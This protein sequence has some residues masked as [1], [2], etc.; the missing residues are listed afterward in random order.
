MNQLAGSNSQ[1][2]TQSKALKLNLDP[3]IYGTFAEIGAGQEIA[4]W[5]FRVGG[6]SGTVAKS[7][8]AYDMK[9]SDD[10][11]GKTT[12]YV[13]EE[14]LKSMLEYE[15]KLLNDRLGESEGTQRTFF[16]LANTIS[17]RNYA[18][19]N[20]CHGWM[21]IRFQTESLREPNDILLHVNLLDPDNLLQ[22]KAIGTLGVNLIY[23]A[24]HNNN[25]I[26]DFL[27]SLMDGLT[28]E[29]IEIDV[30]RFLGKKFSDRDDHLSGAMLV[31]SGL[32]K[33]VIFSPDGKLIQPS[34]L[35]RKK[36]A[37]IERGAFR[38][39]NELKAETLERAKKVFSEDS[40]EN[41][42]NFI[43]EF[44]M[45]SINQ[46]KK[47]TPSE[48]IQVINSLTGRNSYIM[49]SSFSWFY[50]LSHYMRRYTNEPLSF[51]MGISTAI[52]LL[53]ESSYDEESGELLE[54]IGK[55]LSIGVK[56]LSY[57][58]DLDAV[59]NYL[60]I[61][62]LS[63][64]NWTY[65]ENNSSSKSISLKSIIPNSNKA[66]LYNYLISSGYLKEV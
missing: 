6:A 44:S 8:S 42:F 19:T 66:H 17:A 49:I 23:S 18:G 40:H 47:T 22:Q 43:T 1:L 65:L 36:A 26:E 7:M 25:S 63:E 3:R 21:G 37:L 11:Y 31:H 55:L 50:S 16:A 29:R 30:V 52:R 34:S 28:S 10:I 15:Y 35:I 33:A 60:K 13:S 45:C 46:E 2:D 32:A 12:R 27:T 24:Y 62:D 5:F 58:M 38:A 14:R 53:D 39:I 61:K 59:L 51:M 20:E 41:D 9:V 48:A 57:Q 4:G 64:I 56:I 54:A